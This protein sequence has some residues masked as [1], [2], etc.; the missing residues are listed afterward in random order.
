M[1][2]GGGCGTSQIMFNHFKT[3]NELVN[4]MPTIREQLQWNER[5]EPSA[6][7]HR[8]TWQVK[9]D[10]VSSPLDEHVTSEPWASV[11]KIPGQLETDRQAGSFPS[12]PG[13]INTYFL[14]SLPTGQRW[15]ISSTG[16]TGYCQSCAGRT[17]QISCKWLTHLAPDCPSPPALSPYCMTPDHSV[18]AS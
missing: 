13:K 16:R 7:L 11:S 18:V 1:E 3:H 4:T 2:A 9:W 6:V 12:H 5:S 14:H 8:A 15:N 17:T 10:R